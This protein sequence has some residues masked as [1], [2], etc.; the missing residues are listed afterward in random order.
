MMKAI[1]Q[2]SHIIDAEGQTVGRLATRIAGLL[3][4]KGKRTYAPHIDGGD[5]VMVSNIKKVKISPK[6]LLQSAHRHFS[7]YPGGLK[8]TP[9]EIILQKNPDKLLRQAV[10]RMLP[11][12]KLRTHMIK[13]LKIE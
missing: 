4:G 9:W 7:G 11:K 2:K 13:R 12:N 3:M 10:Y 5:L 6:K 8:T 1:E